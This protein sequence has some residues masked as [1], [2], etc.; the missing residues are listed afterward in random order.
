MVFKQKN[1]NRWWYKFVWNSELIRE[2]TKHSFGHNAP[3]PT[4]RPQAQTRNFVILS[5]ILVGAS[6]FEPPTSWSRI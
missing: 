3:K 5:E 1:S 2:S 4:P 6:G